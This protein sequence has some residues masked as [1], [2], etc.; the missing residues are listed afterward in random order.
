MK[1]KP[2]VFVPG[3]PSSELRDAGTGKL[4]F[5]PNP[6]DLFSASKKKALL[7]RLCGPDDPSV[8][9]G[10]VAGRP[11]RHSARIFGLDVGRQADSLYDA[12]DR[13]GY[14]VD[15]AGNSNDFRAVGWD[16]RL[17]VD[18][19]STQ[20][21]LRHSIEDLQ[22][23]SGQKVVVIVHSTGGL[24]FR[25][26]LES[27]ELAH[28]S[29]FVS[30]IDQLVSI[31]VPWAGTL[32]AVRCVA[33]GV[34]L[35]PGLITAKESRELFG[36]AHSA[37]DLMPPDPQR[38]AMSD[39]DGDLFLA[40]NATAFATSPLVDRGW[41]GDRTPWITR[42]KNADVRF[43]ARTPAFR[44]GGGVKLKVSNVVGYG[45]PT[46]ISCRIRAGS[47]KM[48]DDES[49]EPDLH[50]SDG[51]GTVPRRSAAWLRGP[52]VTT[53]LAPAGIYDSKMGG[54]HSQLWDSK[55]VRSLLERLLADK[56]SQPFL[57]AALDRSDTAQRKR[58]I[59]I[60]VTA[61]SADG[62]ALAGCVVRFDPG[63]RQATKPWPI[64]NGRT[65]MEWLRP[66]G[67]QGSSILCPITVSWTESGQERTW[68]ADFLIPS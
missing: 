21:R 8:D 68:D 63:S 16:W 40:R 62:S 24:V 57:H 54:E 58:K 14:D 2:V 34:G 12:L 47:I 44:L 41:L 29:A 17:P 50:S 9:D 52:D 18:H 4:L 32:K 45:V 61:Q 49:K 65:V 25:A 19:H 3:F 60:R 13:L 37:Y 64:P 66:P 26:L 56:P 39:A 42:A 1:M 6:A 10:I 15:E 33:V 22:Q 7:K 30:K 38:T 5:P 67:V 28:Q 43:G 35:E 36:T 46:D 48:S 31:G 27:L 55:P 53:F 23:K 20:S 11:I 51:D 59:R